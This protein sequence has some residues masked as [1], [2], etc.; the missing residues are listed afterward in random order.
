MNPK[1]LFELE[2]RIE[3]IEPDL[4]LPCPYDDLISLTVY[5]VK[6]MH[7]PCWGSAPLYTLLKEA[8]STYLRYGAVSPLDDYDNKA[9]IYIARANY[10]YNNKRITEWLSLRFVPYEGGPEGFEDI[11]LYK[12]YGRTKL[13]SVK[14]LINRRILKKSGFG[15]SDVVSGSRICGINPYLPYPGYVTDR[16]RHNRFAGL[17]FAAMHRQFFRDYPD[18]K[19]LISQIPENFL[20]NV[21][22]AADGYVPRLT[23]ADQALEIPAREK[24]YLDRL[25]RYIYQFPF[26]FFDPAGILEFLQALYLKNIISEATLI[27]YFGPNLTGEM[28]RSG[29]W[30]STEKLRNLGLI[31]SADGHIYGSRLTGGILQ[32]MLLTVRDGPKLRIVRMPYLKR[33]INK[34]IGD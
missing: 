33:V 31:T 23:T 12:L 8:R 18:F 26:Y 9:V 1:E 16:P 7:N 22:A 3:S 14:G 30:P 29:N 32:I 11:N 4:Q 15:W 34:M 21:L 13:H 10:L 5:R 6:K 2:E 27:H 24:I 19:L 28:I 20:E 17:C 25:N